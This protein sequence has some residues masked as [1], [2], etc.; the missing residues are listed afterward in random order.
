MQNRQGLTW[1]LEEARSPLAATMT[2]AF[3]ETW[4]VAEA[5]GLSLRSATW[6]TSAGE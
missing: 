5:E 6:R 2:Q 4:A 3:D 1:P